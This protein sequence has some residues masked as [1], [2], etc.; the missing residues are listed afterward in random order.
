MTE[1]WLLDLVAGEKLQVILFTCHTDWAA[2]WKKWQPKPN[3]THA[4]YYGID[5]HAIG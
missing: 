2:D 1:Q 5:W 4:F 3:E